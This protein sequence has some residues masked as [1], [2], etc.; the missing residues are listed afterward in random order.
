MM[1]NASS[2]ATRSRYEAN[3]FLY[4]RKDD[5]DRVREFL[6]DNWGLPGTAIVT[7]MHVTVYHA[8]RKLLGLQI[9]SEPADVEIDI[10]ESRFMVLAPGGENP[11]PELEPSKLRVGIRI[12]KRD[13]CLGQILEY[14]RRFYAYETAVVLGERKPSGDKTSAFGA[15]H[16]QPHISLLK[17][18]NDV[19]R[20]L[21][22]IGDAFRQRFQCLRLSKFIV[23]HN[24]D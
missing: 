8:R 20:D 4:L 14:R 21:T 6:V 23:R 1:T 15:R 22:L 12:G 17:P 9:H 19:E 7:G 10:A 16:Y 13:P 24:Y 5:E 2:S 3:A 11:R 18:G